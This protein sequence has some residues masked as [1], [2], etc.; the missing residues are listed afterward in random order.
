MYFAFRSAALFAACLLAA[1][2]IAARE[3][4]V[5]ADPDNLPYSHEDES[6]FENRIARVVAEEMGA[7]LRY[8][9][10]PLRRGFVRKTM[11]EGVCD[12][13]MGVPHDFERVT[14]TKPYYR[15]SY[16]FVDGPRARDVES[17]DDPRLASLTI[18]VQ[19]VGNDMAATPPGHALASKGHVDNVRG[20]AVFGDAPA[21]ERMVRALA[22]GELDAALIWGPQAGYFAA[23][24]NAPL[25]IRPASAPAGLEKMPF[26]FDISIGVKRGN[27]ALR[28]ELDQILE[29]RRAQIDAILAAYHVPRT[30]LRAEAAK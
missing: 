9:W 6:G 1:S 22:R 20:Y 19:L 4:R 13:F 5:C 24:S 28:D 11:G 26:E 8:E 3:L 7:E 2:G 15:S 18:G 25:A 14:T 10:W 21:A 16:V 29:R 27:T 23:R 30:D 12:V 17:F